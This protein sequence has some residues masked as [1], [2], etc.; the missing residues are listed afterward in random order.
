M[1]IQPDGSIR[2]YP[3]RGRLWALLLGAVAFV[4][5]G[6]WII[7]LRE[8]AAI[9]HYYHVV[10]A[11][12]AIAFFGACA[13][14]ILV[15]IFNPSAVVILSREGITDSASPF[16]VGF[17]CWDEIAFLSVYTI[18]GQ[19]MLGIYLKDARSIMARVGGA[20]AKYMELN[21]RLGFAPVNIP[22]VVLPLPVEELAE[23]IRTR[24][25]VEERPR[26]AA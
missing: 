10:V 13:V 8:H 16:G 15:R 24:Y 25:G 1:D 14:A 5:L 7:G 12:V 2:I 21:L 6:F 9:V 26:Q 19:R 17:L 23:L 3:V 22:Q 18:E 4:A 20:K 11:V